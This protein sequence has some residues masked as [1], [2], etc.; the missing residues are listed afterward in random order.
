MMTMANS[1]ADRVR[2]SLSGDLGAFEELVRQHQGAAYG[3]ALAQLRDPSAAQDAV[4][5]ALVDAYFNLGQLREPAAFGGWLRRIVF[6][7]CDRQRRRRRSVTLPAPPAQASDETSPERLLEDVQRR[8]ALLHAI[9]R[10][11]EHERF[12][13]ALHY[14]AGQPVKAIAE[15][16]SLSTSAVKKRLFSARR[17]FD[18]EEL[19]LARSA[20]EPTPQFENRI[21][22]FIAIRS[23]DHA[24]VDRILT[25]QPELLEAEERWSDEEALA[26]G[27]TLAHHLTPLILAAGYGDLAMVDLLLRLGASPAG[28]CGCDNGETALWAASRAGHADVAERLVEAGACAA[29]TNDKGYDAAAL[30]RWRD[31]PQP[32]AASVDGDRITTG[33]KA[34]DLW[35]PLE[36]GAVV[37]VYGAAETGLT[38]LM[39]EIAGAIGRA[40]GRSVWTSWEPRPWH[41]RELE[42]LAARGAIDDLV[43]IVTPD[44]QEQPRD[45]LRRGLETTRALGASHDLVAHVIF[46][47]EGHRS[48]VEAAFPE[49]GDTAAVTFVVGPW[50]AATRGDLGPPAAGPHDAV[51]CTDA[52][53]AAQWLYPAIDPLRTCSRSGSR[54]VAAQARRLI[55]RYAQIDAQLRA[56]EADEPQSHQIVRRARCLLSYLTQPF[57]CAEP[58]T[59]WPAVAVTAEDT[60]D[61][62]KRIVAGDLDDVPED[63]LRYRGS[64]SR[65]HG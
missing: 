29:A 15:F 25:A 14:L 44:G 9:E 43:E 20:T 56:T 5:D 41:R 49:L 58:D 34:L 47:Q 54:A 31:R 23:G 11:P 45:V 17:R 22:L 26:G 48:V 52:R 36:R 62:V 18:E 2:A 3:Y 53:L 12:V 27:F 39:S 10:L 21:A 32:S 30:T 42:V 37:R 55:A 60:L 50:A 1:T 57:A 59:G 28:R 16:L 13:I 6:K 7:H 40:G 64:L 4:Q 63:R 19:V 24:S 38:V 35:L 33:I 51:L 61:D 65:L 8:R 46:E